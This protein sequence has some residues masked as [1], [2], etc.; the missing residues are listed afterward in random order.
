MNKNLIY[1]L[2]TIFIVG[3]LLLVGYYFI[4]FNPKKELE[5]L[6]TNEKIEQKEIE[7][8]KLKED[9]EAEK[10]NKTQERKIDSTAKLII[11][12]GIARGKS[13]KEI[14]QV[15]AE[16]GS[17][18]SDSLAEL[19]DLIKVEVAQQLKE[20]YEDALNN[21]DDPLAQRFIEDFKANRFDPI[22]GKLSN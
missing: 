15:L 3:I 9:L 2:V 10:V 18:T 12:G 4:V 11:S 5:E 14:K 8:E 6:K 1:N 22:T 17:L 13:Y 7:I 19:E 16:N 21:P 20:A